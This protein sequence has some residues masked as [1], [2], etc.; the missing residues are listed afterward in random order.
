MPTFIRTSRGETSQIPG[1]QRDPILVAGRGA[2][3]GCRRHQ[4]GT[5]PTSRSR[6]RVFFH[7]SSRIFPTAPSPYAVTGAV[8]SRARAACR[9]ARASRRCAAGN[10]YGD[11]KYC[12]KAGADVILT[13][14]FGGS[15][16]KLEKVG[17][18]DRLAEVNRAG[19]ELSK[20]A[21][22]QAALVFASVTPR[23]GR[24]ARLGVVALLAL[25]S[26]AGEDE[27]VSLDVDWEALGLG[28]GREGVEADGVPPGAALRVFAPAVE[29]LQP[30]SEVDLSGVTVPAG[31][32]LFVRSLP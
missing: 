1:Q 29:G 27:V 5:T 24:P 17:L 3:H 6:L 22:S 8:F 7:T 26:W 9:E 2:G 31:M 11:V 25:A 19:A 12:I 18:A 28:A 13:N 14:T 30:E 20:R 21:A 4:V 15:R 10:V 32:G 23:G 16:Y